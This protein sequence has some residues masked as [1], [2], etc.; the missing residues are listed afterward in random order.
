M[1]KAPTMFLK[2]PST[3]LSQ[4]KLCNIVIYIYIYK[5]DDKVIFV[6]PVDE[7]ILSPKRPLF[8]VHVSPTLR[9]G[10]ESK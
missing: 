1:V 8:G 5:F 10:G 6:N 3:I 7:S 9:K 2:I 4:T